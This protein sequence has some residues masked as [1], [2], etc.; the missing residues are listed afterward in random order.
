MANT[1][2]KIQT[3][4]V[5]SGGASSIEFTSIP[6][7]YTDLKLVLSARSTT[8]DSTNPW[9]FATISFNGNTSNRTTRFLSGNGSTASSASD[10]TIYT[11]VAGH[12]ATASVFGN[13]EIYIPNYTSANNKSLSIDT[14]TENN[15]TASYMNLQ[16]GLWSNT[17]AI[18]QV[19]ITLD[20]GNFVQYTTATLYGISNANTTVGGSGKATG[21]NQVYTDGTYW[22]H[23]FTSDGTFAPAVSMNVDY[24][25]VAGGG[26]GGSGYG[27]AGGGGGT[28]CTVG[29][30]GGGG[31]LESALA[32]TA[33]TYA[34][35]VGGGG[36]KGSGGANGTVGSDSVFSTITSTGGGRGTQGN[37]VG[38][39]GGSGG[40]GCG[41]GAGG[42]SGSI[43]GGSASPSGQ[44]Y[45]GGSGASNGSTPSGGGGGGAGAVGGNGSVG[46]GGAGGAGIQTSISGTA[47][48]YAGGGGGG[49]YNGTGGS[50]TLTTGG[51]T[52]GVGGTSGGNTA[53]NVASNTGGGGGGAGAG[54]GAGGNGGSG[55][56]IVRYAA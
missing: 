46:T 32:V 34:I 15:A 37:T 7:T 36:P 42:S 55:I 48:Y 23:V 43:A 49:C 8:S 18:T 1:L 2:K 27:G 54:N 40:G 13:A 45:N 51:G 53:A 35:T 10:T 9:K 20:T 24:L 16:A 3:I 19:T 38:G 56:V 39:N 31:S 26:G 25:V 11:W 22:Y 44:G 4:T 47:T 5:G 30:T 21:G 6:Q 17:A 28:R 12:N 41:N 33:Q 50:G 29:A 14:V 52:A